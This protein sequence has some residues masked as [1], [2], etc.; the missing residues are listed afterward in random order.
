MSQRFA[1]NAF[2]AIVRAVV[3]GQI[4]LFPPVPASYAGEQRI[5]AGF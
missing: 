3:I 4:T 5:F 1:R 2:I